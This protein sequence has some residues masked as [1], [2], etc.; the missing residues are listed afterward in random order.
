[1]NKDDLTDRYG[2]PTVRVRYMTVNSVYATVEERYPTVNHAYPT[3]NLDKISKLITYRL[4]FLH[5]VSERE[6]H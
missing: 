4:A 3:V 6:I 5:F 1:M 2:Y